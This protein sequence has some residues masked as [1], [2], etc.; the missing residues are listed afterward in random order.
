LPAR[1]SEGSGSDGNLSRLALHDPAGRRYECLGSADIRLAF[2]GI[3]AKGEI[4][5]LSG[6]G[7]YV[8][9]DFAIEVGDQIEMTLH[10]NKTSFP[11]TASVIHVCATRQNHYIPRTAMRSAVG[12][13]R[14]CQLATTCQWAGNVKHAILVD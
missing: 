6:G 5:N 13:S 11:V 14:Q 4:A 8:M 1:S 3:L 2:A 10:V 12:H 9:T 7:C